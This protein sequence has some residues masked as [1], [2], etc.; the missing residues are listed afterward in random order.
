MRDEFRKDVKETL[1]LRV[2][3]RCSICDCPTSGPTNE[4]DGRVLV[5][6]AAHIH[7]A[8]RRGPRY[9]PKQTPEE[10]RSAENGIWLC[11]GHAKEV[12]DDKSRYTA[13]EL[14]RIKQAAEERARNTLLIPGHAKAMQNWSELQTSKISSFTVPLKLPL[15]PGSMRVAKANLEGFVEVV[16]RWITAAFRHTCVATSFDDFVF[17]LSLEP[18]DRKVPNGH[19]AYDLTVYCHITAFI[20]AFETWAPFFLEGARDLP[21]RSQLRDLP[22]DQRLEIPEFGVGRLIPC[23]ISRSGPTSIT[24]H[25]VD[26]QPISM[27]KKLKTSG[28]LRL[29]CAILKEKTMIWDDADKSLDTEKVMRMAVAMADHGFSWDQIRVN[30]KYPESWRITESR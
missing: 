8:S 5:G 11:A 14:R 13:P 15:E 28:L 10:R 6:V 16:A 19:A 12:D 24:L 7:G 25:S 22:G 20:W 1:S 29:L 3:L 30:R 23:R 17:V 18:A 4:P 21:G 26:G 27:E 9:N 2:C